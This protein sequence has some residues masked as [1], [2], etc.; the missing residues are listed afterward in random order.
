MSIEQDIETSK[1]KDDLIIEGLSALSY[2]T[3][4]DFFI[5]RTFSG[6]YRTEPCYI[7]TPKKVRFAKKYSICQKY[8]SVGKSSVREK[9]D[10]RTVL[11]CVHF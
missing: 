8:G 11:P 5:N 4:I 7:N 6:P 10:G 2:S 1:D 3:H 9:V